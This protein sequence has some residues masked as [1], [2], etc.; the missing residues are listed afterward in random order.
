MKSPYFLKRCAMK[1]FKLFIIFILLFSFPFFI[2]ADDLNESID[3]TAIATSSDSVSEP[4]IYSRRALVFER[5][6]KTVLFEKNSKEQCKMASTTKIMTSILILENCNL[7]DMVTVSSK[8]GGTTGS[9]L[10]I[11]ADDSISVND[12]LYGLMLCSGNDTAV[13][14]AEYCSGSVEEFAN[15][16]NH[17]AQELQLSSTHFVTPHGLDNDEHYTT[18]YDF[19]ILT[20]YAMNNPLFLQI[21]GTKYYTVSINGISKSIHNTNELLGVIPS[22]YGIKTGY[23]SGAGRCLITAAKENNLDIIV[24]VFG[25]DTKKIRTDDSSKLINYIF[26]NYEAIDL[27]KLVSDKYNEYTS[28]LL[29]LIDIPKSSGSLTTKLD[30]INYSYYPV[31]KDLI[32]SV[33]VSL[34]TVDLSAPV[35]ENQ[36]VGNINVYL[37]DSKILGTNILSSSYISKK[38]S[39]DYFFYFVNNYKNFYKVY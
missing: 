1:F 33:S 30:N 28:F 31:K 29:P 13:A 22:V 8:A 3:N 17:K 39:F 38:S 37:N 20:D 16:M 36:I 25:A 27:S 35:N 19:A 14:L 12:L 5:N 18:A 9:R 7:S 32:N 15:L 4:E 34:E 26:S 24:I 21:V 2:Y 23:T 6:S 10:G 11:H